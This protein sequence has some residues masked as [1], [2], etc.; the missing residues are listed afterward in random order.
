VI[1]VIQYILHYTT[2]TAF[3]VAGYIDLLHQDS[4][5]SPSSESNMFLNFFIAIRDLV[6]IGPG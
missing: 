6:L 2:I 4:F 1:K 5:P 3:I